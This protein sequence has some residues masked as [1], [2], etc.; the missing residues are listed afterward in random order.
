MVH[1][2]NYSDYILIKEKHVNSMLLHNDNMFSM[3]SFNNVNVLYP[4]LLS[5]FSKKYSIDEILLNREQILLTFKS[6]IYEILNIFNYLSNNQ[7]ETSPTMSYNELKNNFYVFISLKYG[8]AYSFYEQIALQLSSKIKTFNIT[9]NSD[10][11]NCVELSDVE[12]HLYGFLQ[13]HFGVIYNTF[14]SQDTIIE[15]IHIES[16]ID[17][18]NILIDH[19]S[20]LEKWFIHFFNSLVTYHM[21]SLITSTD[22]NVIRLLTQYE[23]FLLF[24]LLSHDSVYNERMFFY[25]NDII[26]SNES[27]TFINTKVHLINNWFFYTNGGLFNIFYDFYKHYFLYLIASY[28]MEIRI[29][30]T[31]R[32]FADF[33][34]R[35]YSTCTFAYLD[36]KTN[37]LVSC[38]DD[39]LVSFSYMLDIVKS[40][41]IGYSKRFRL[42]YHFIKKNN[43]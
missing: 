38:Y 13:E 39:K 7:F 23:Y 6:S 24:D 1:L 5:K 42:L 40:L 4:N 32:Y 14:N 29:R 30:K 15:P 25:E 16:L 37:K 33:L 41:D 2:N 9:N 3:Y 34:K 10:F 22:K 20:I 12:K 27:I 18:F 17:H 28:E 8:D 36:I 11:I 31:S 35:N 19:F 43:V 26:D 21:T